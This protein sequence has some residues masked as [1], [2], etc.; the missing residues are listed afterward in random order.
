MPLQTTSGPIRAGVS[1]RF[2]GM[3]MPHEERPELFRDVETAAV[4][5]IGDSVVPR[6]V[7]HVRSLFEAGGVGDLFQS[8]D[9]KGV[10][11]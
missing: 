9:L 2:R 3:E 1:T 11:M 7:M 8:R 6:E 10:T 5:P 4:A